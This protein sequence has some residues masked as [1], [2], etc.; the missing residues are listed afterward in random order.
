MNK[1][2]LQ[3]LAELIQDFISLEDFTLIDDDVNERSFAYA[4][5]FLLNLPDGLSVPTYDIHPDGEFSYVWRSDDAGILAIAFSADG[6]I[7]Y[8]SYLPENNTRHKGKILFT[9]MNFKNG[10]RITPPAPDQDRA[11]FMRV[12][13]GE[14]YTS[15]GLDYGVGKERIRQRFQRHLRRLRRYASTGSRHAHSAD[16]KRLMQYKLSDLRKVREFWLDIDYHLQ[17]DKP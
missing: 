2:Y 8:A 3:F 9:D 11:I 13:H 1:N 17:Q 14:T 7:N 6:N 10:S 15:V 12:I 4:L 16:A 5:E